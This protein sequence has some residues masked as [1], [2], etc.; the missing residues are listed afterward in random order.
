MYKINE[1]I[2]EYL[3]IMRID[4]AHI[5]VYTIA[6]RSNKTDQQNKIEYRAKVEEVPERGKRDYNITSG[7]R[8]REIERFR[9]N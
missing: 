6:I 1:N 7:N 5:Y 4:Y 3:C 9:S 2:H 8:I